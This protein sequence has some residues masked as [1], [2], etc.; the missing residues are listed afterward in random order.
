MADD[1]YVFA[2]R[3]YVSYTLILLNVSIHLMQLL[4]PDRELELAY[5]LVPAMILQGQ[6]L[7]T[8]ITSMFLHA[9]PYHLL[10]NMYFFFIFSGPVEKEL[11]PLVFIPFYI[12]SGII[13]G[14]GHILITVTLEAIFFPL[15][16]YIM[17][18]GASGAIFGVMAGFAYLI[19][20]RRLQVWSGYGETGRD[21]A[22]W[23]FIIF[24]FVIEIVFLVLSL[25]SSIAHGAHVFGFVGG[26][27][28]A[29]IFRRIKLAREDRSSEEYPSLDYFE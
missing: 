15:A 10:S 5:T 1:N 3:P 12:F 4:T 7:H 19:P 11:G 24:Y 2:F 16:P 18:L 29:I 13:G 23:N 17:T 22:A 8:L 21:M 25:G 27:L 9:D 14:L 26:Y 20:R 28:F 6:N